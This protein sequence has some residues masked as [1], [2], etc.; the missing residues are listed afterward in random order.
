M[1]LVLGLLPLAFIGFIGWLIYRTVKGKPFTLKA[2]TV[3]YGLA[4]VAGIF[5]FVFFLSMDIP[6]LVKVMVSIFLGMVLIILAAYFQRRR[7]PDK[8]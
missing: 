2:H 1:S 7:Q 3:T 8:Q 5:T 4:C 6:Q